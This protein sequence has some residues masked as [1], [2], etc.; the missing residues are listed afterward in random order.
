[1][2]RLR[3]A[4][5]ALPVVLVAAGLA[6]PVI[7]DGGASRP[8]APPAAEARY[9][10]RSATEWRALAAAA[11]DGEDFALAIKYLKTAEKVEPGRQYSGE[12]ARVRA[13]RK[14]ALDVA[15]NCD[16]MIGSQPQ[17]LVLDEGGNVVSVHRTTVALPGE[18]LW[19]VAVALQAAWQRVLPSEVPAGSPD[20]YATWDALTDV[21]GLRE[22]EVGETV[23]LPL[24]RPELDAISRANAE[25]MERVR[26]AEAALDGGDVER[27]RS[28]RD[29]IRGDFALGSDGL[30]ALDARIREARSAQLLATAREIL[31]AAPDISRPSRHHELVVSL[32][33]ARGLLEEVRGLS[34][35]LPDGELERVEGLL[36]EAERYRLDPEGNIVATKPA[37]MAYTEFARATVEWFIAR[38][39]AGSGAEYPYSDRKT[40]DEVAWADY[41]QGAS[42]LADSEGVDFAG[43][44]T[45]PDE[46]AVRLPNPGS[47]FRE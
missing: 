41:M 8:P 1:M 37:G 18:S 14:R 10:G 26:L 33:R 29:A 17:D 5:I 21:N 23:R 39:L 13:A 32:R 6:I 24:S 47:Y 46:R 25:D 15:S 35:G 2:R 38:K 30:R 31:E 45:D 9:A 7:V 16:R 42:S 43:L 11:L 4:T 22:L 44:L 34:G 36:A 28:L 27:A 20:V 19:S 12:L 3:K 40:A